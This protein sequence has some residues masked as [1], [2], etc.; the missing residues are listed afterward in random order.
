MHWV[1]WE[2]LCNSKETHQ[3]DSP[4]GLFVNDYN[5]EDGC[6]PEPFPEMDQSHLI[7]AI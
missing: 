4:A 6:N 2:K 3:L 5:I 1:A 7:D